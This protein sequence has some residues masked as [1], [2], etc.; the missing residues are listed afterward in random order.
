MRFT[1]LLIILLLLSNISYAIDDHLLLTEAVATPTAGEFIEIANPTATAIALDN[2]YLS[3]DEDYAFLPGAS[4]AGPAPNVG[5]S[6]FIAQFPAGT[7]IAP[8]QVITI[9]F[10]GTGFFNEYG[11]NADYEIF[12]GPNIAAD[13]AMLFG[14]ATPGL[15]NSGENAVLFTWD[16][17]SDLV[18]DVD[19]VNL[20]TPSATN[21][22]GNKTGVTVDGPDADTITSTYANESASM[23]QMLNDAGFGTSAK[24]IALEIGQEVAGGNGLNG[25]DETSE[26]I[27]VTW[28]SPHTAPDPG[29]FGGLPSIDLSLTKSVNDAAP[30]QGND[31]IFTLTV[32][33]SGADAATGVSVLDQ[34]PAGLAYV[35]DNSGGNYVPGTGI[36]TI[37]SI[38]GAGATSILTIT[39]TANQLGPITNIAEVAT[40]DQADTD[41]IPG[42]DDGDQSEDDEDN[43]TITVGAIPVVDLSLSKT[44]DNLTPTLGG[45][46]TFTLT[47]SNAGPDDATGVVVTDLLP[48]GLDYVSDDSGAYVPG[49]GVWTVGAIANGG[50]ATL[51]IVT[52]LTLT[53][54]VVNI[55]EITGQDQMDSDSIPGN[56]SGNQSEDD[57]DNVLIRILFPPAIPVPTLSVWSL[58]LATLSLLLMGL[59]R[60]RSKQS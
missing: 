23:P 30:I 42:N 57:E 28:S 35:S 22:I 41:S 18:Q 40:Q 45:N 54:P 29:V 44:A 14:G 6:D 38:A 49:T 1:K 12:G 47:V 10:S 53:G 19:M 3:D 26:N 34:L 20:G 21:D 58:I 55:T 46:V 13:M 50:S 56:D 52:E 8:G 7:S 11:I 37:G 27:T 43:A 32:T 31:V 59:Y 15:T 24:R 2:Y 16:G 9:A 4:G 51:N 60:V 25:D 36:W 5:A 48:A 39:A 33:N 17:M